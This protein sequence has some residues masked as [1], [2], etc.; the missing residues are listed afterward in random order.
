ME[1]FGKVPLRGLAHAPSQRQ[2]SPFI[3]DMD[4]QRGTPTAHAAAI[5]D[6]HH[7]LQGEMTQQDVCIGQKVHLLQDMSIVAPPGKAF[8]PALGLGAIGNLG[9]D[10]G[11]LGAL[12]AHDA[13]NKRG[14]G[15]QVPGDCPGGLARI[16]L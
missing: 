11:Q 16:S 5:H 15:R 8:D 9:G 2:G 1:V 13:A 4:H 6:E 12:T 3:D 14:E 10:V 7:C